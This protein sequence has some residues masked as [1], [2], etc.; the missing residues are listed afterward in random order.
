MVASPP[1]LILITGNMAAG[2]STIAQ[3]IAEQLEKS[4]HLRGDIFRRMIVQG[5]AALDTT[6]AEEAERQLEL[7]YQLA[8]NV[9]RG[10]LAA[11]FWVVYQD[12]FLGKGLTDAITRLQDLSPLVIVLCPDAH[13]VA[14]REAS[15]VKSGYQD[16]AD[17][18]IFDRILREQ[19]PRVGYWLD[20]TELSVEE[21]VKRVLA[22]I[23][24]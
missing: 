8:E 18:E 1:R 17:I 22:Y 16:R 23:R 19:T 24:G 12:I 13:T 4:V 15:R 10:Y 3:A 7:R 11:G 21:T 5:R 2:K 6:L 20:T 9:A 14:Q